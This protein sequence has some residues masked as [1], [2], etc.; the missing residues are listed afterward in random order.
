MTNTS[1]AWATSLLAGAAML[2]TSVGG[3]H[4]AISL[5]SWRFSTPDGGYLR[6]ELLSDDA[7][8]GATNV[9]S[10]FNN[11][12][13]FWPGDS[14]GRAAS[15]IALGTVAP[16]GVATDNIWINNPVPGGFHMTGNGFAAHVD[17]DPPPPPVPPVNP[18]SP[19]YVADFWA[20]DVVF[21]CLTQY[22]DGTVEISKDGQNHF[23]PLAVDS[24][25]EPATWALM[26]GGFGLAGADLR[27]RR[28]AVAA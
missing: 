12:L 26:L 28:T 22:P 17:P 24:I 14:V 15:L 23:S 5:G 8:I 21:C 3:A 27:R 20:T 4:A 1:R 11:A 10:G 6:A 7:A 19:Q 9:I 25:P 16:G 2:A 13:Y 18:P